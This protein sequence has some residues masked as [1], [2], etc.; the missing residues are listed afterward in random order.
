MQR[1]RLSKRMEHIVTIRLPYI[2]NLDTVLGERSASSPDNIPVH[3][4][5]TVPQP[6]WRYGREKRP[7]GNRTQV[8]QPAA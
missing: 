2:L 4:R 1:Y 6:V 7:V 8:V 5:P 3:T